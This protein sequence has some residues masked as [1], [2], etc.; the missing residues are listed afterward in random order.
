MKPT[1]DRIRAG[2]ATWDA[3]RLLDSQDTTVPDGPAVHF[4]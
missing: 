4:Q 2:V 1:F 3:E